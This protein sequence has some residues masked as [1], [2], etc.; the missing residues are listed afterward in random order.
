[1]SVLEIRKYPDPVLKKKSL[2]VVDING[3]LQK[4]IDNMVETMHAAPGIGLA[5]PQVGKS[6]RL[7]V[8]DV[9]TREEIHPL[10]VLINPDIVQAE[11]RVVYEEGCLS[12]PGYTSSIPRE[13][14]VCVRGFDR[15]GKPVE[16]EATGLLARALQHEID[17]LDGTLFVDRMSPI[18]RE[19]FRKRYLKKLRQT[20]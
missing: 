18:K 16:I 1:M 10:I 6:K 9:S 20:A 4:L 3:T 15:N 13:E 8:I 5:A 12:V 7:I 14:R 19:F 11:G 2:P 17:H